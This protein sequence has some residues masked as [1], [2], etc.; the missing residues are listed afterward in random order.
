MNLA[1]LFDSHQLN[2]FKPQ[3]TIRFVEKALKAQRG[4][5]KLEK[6]S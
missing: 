3:N 6:E 4:L 1:V 2:K 5:S